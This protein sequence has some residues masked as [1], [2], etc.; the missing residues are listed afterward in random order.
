[1]VRGLGAGRRV[2]RGLGAGRRVVRGL[3]AGRREVGGLTAGS[4]KSS[5]FCLACDE[6]AALDAKGPA[7]GS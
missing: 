2:V 5:C 6:D 4:T 7:V 3:G 1:M